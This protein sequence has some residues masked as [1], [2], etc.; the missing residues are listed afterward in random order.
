M[1]SP[2]LNIGE[3]PVGTHEGEGGILVLKETLPSNS[4]TSPLL[5]WLAATYL[6]DCE[7]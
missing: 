7:N 5:L 3:L 1:L 2:L 4:L 6:W